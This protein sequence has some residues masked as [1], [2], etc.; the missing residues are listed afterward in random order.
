MRPTAHTPL[1]PYART[2][3][4]PDGIV[5]ASDGRAASDAALLAAHAI[6]PLDTFGVLTVLTV[7]SK[8]AAADCT[9][10]PVYDRAAIAD[11]AARIRAQLERLFGSA[12]GVRVETRS[13]YPP[14]VVAAYAETHDIDLLVVGIG[15]PRVID[16][17]LGDEST[18]RLARLSKTPIFA[19]AGG[20]AV[21]PRRIVVGIDFTP[22][23]IQAARLAIDLAAPDAEVLLAHV[24]TL[25]AR[26]RPDASLRRVVEVVQTCFCGRVKSQ[27]LRGDAATEVLALATDWN[28]DAIA[29][30]LHG[31]GPEDRAAIGNVATR[32]VRCASCSVIV[33]P[34]KA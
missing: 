34:R 21:P 14:A 8:S 2:S 20:V 12:D 25:D 23:S 24:E 19:V 26:S 29:I 16:R 17:L 15:R 28:A 32:V 11:N 18:L 27:L 6:A 5:V 31:H 9:I 22:T 7:L 33:A 30:G 3:I 4:R 1:R 10:E 13:G